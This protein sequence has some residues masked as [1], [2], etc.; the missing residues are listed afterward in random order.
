ME[1]LIKFKRTIIT[2]ILITT[3]V[4]AAG[5]L[6][7][8]YTAAAKGFILGSFFSLFNF[9]IMVRRAPDLL[10][11][12]RKSATVFSGLSLLL[13]LGLMALPLYLALQMPDVDVIWTVLGLFNLQFS[14]IIYGQVVERFGLTGGPSV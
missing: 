3:A 1:Q 8:D 2:Q 14:I 4:V 9:I 10:G 6:F 12:E 7:M 13:R 5:A 11:R